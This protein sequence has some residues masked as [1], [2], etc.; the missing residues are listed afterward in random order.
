MRYRHL[1]YLPALLLCCTLVSIGCRS[2][3]KQTPKQKVQDTTVIAPSQSNAT[4]L[5]EASIDR[6]TFAR[7]ITH[8]IDSVTAV[9][10][11]LSPKKA[12]QLYTIT[13]AFIDSQLTLYCGD[14]HFLDWYSDLDSPDMQPDSVRRE[15]TLYRSL[16]ME[17]WD[18]G[19]GILELR[20]MPDFY[21]RVFGKYLSPDYLSFVQLTCSEDSVLYQ[22]DAGI[23]IPFTAVADRL[24]HWEAF[25][26]KCPGSGL[27]K[28]AQETYAYYLSGYLLGEDNT[29]TFENDVMQE[30]ALNAYQQTAGKYPDTYTGTLS[31]QF[32]EKFKD[33]PS[34]SDE[35]HAF[36]DHAAQVIA[37][38]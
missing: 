31:R 2:N 9:L 12:D 6:A 15:I 30:E 37:S 36:A 16:H 32:L 27:K 3:H 25:I 10:P 13:K 23:L 22:A 29:P 7:R 8:L 1:S 35:R 11:G 5:S 14:A 34:D 38:Q 21:V 26:R 4:R 17:P 18:I 24:L 33:Q 28:T 20:T 19:E